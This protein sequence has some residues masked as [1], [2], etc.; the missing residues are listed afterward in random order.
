MDFSVIIWI[1]QHVKQRYLGLKLE[2]NFSRI[3]KKLGKDNENIHK[4]VD[5]RIS[6]VPWLDWK[7]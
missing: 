4:E 2:K 3:E 5:Y 6:V 7:T 1:F